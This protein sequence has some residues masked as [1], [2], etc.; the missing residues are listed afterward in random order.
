MEFT[1]LRD[2]GLVG[3]AGQGRKLGGGFLAGFASFA[4]IAAGALLA[5]ARWF[6]TNPSAAR[7]VEIVLGA[8]LT[9]VTVAVLEE[10]LFRGVLFGSLRKVFNWKFALVLTSAFYALVHFLKSVKTSE[11]VT[12]TSGFEMLP[13]LFRG[14]ADL[15]TAIPGFFNL[16]LAG[17]L[18]GLAY[19]RTG[20]LFF[21]IGLHAGWIFWLK[22]YLRCLVASPRPQAW[23][24]GSEKMIDGWFALM[25]LAA[26]LLIYSR[27]SAGKK[28]ELPHERLL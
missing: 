25:V 19:Q 15:R 22:F 10:V 24:W 6:N 16:T 2:V 18:L 3:F 23:W 14:F 9:A 5:G 26:T 1:S 17:A 28:G 13:L 20:N 8:A 21:S 7:W 12:W 11:A 4:V 27:L